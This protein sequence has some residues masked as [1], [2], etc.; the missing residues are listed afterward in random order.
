[1]ADRS[2][3]ATPVQST[4]PTFGETYTAA[5]R[6]DH[7]AH[8]TH[9]REVATSIEADAAEYGA[10]IQRRDRLT[11]GPRTTRTVAVQA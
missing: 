2:V 11:L 10:S 7:L 5:T 9:C 6:A 4:S 1:M 8:C 3:P